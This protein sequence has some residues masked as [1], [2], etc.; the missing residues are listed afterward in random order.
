MEC[1]NNLSGKE[2]AEGDV[3]ANFWAMSVVK[4]GC[5]LVIGVLILNS[6]F[7]ASNIT[8]SSPFYNM[9][10][11]VISKTSSGYTLVALMLIV[12]GSGAILHLLGFM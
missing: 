10:N 11:S 2:P 7:I 5:L 1:V 4:L 9:Y 12:L 6:V 3:P 8:T